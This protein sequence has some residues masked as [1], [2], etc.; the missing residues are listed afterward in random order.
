MTR[1]RTGHRLNAL[2][3]YQSAWKSQLDNV[4]AVLG[5]CV[6]SGKTALLDTS[7]GGLKIPEYE[8]VDSFVK[9]VR[10]VK[11]HKKTRYYKVVTVVH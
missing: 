6:N 4:S 2:F 5:T 8:T 10:W 9:I 7:L 3:A 11:T 1:D